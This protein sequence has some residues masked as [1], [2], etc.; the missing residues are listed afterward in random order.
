MV[1]QTWVTWAEKQMSYSLLRVNS[2]RGGEFLANMFCTFLQSKGVEHQLSV[3]DHHQQNGHAERFNCTL[4]EKEET[5][6]HT[7]CLPKHLWNFALDTAVHVYNRT[8]MRHLTW[9]TPI[10]LVFNKNLISHTCEY[11]DVLH[12]FI[13]QRI[14]KRTSSH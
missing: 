3:V 10:E 13:S 2:D 7:A 12:M 8:P 5:M 11:S 4:L 6:C 9:K 1:F 14:N